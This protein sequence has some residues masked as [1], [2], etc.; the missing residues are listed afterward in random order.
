MLFLADIPIMIAWIVLSNRRPLFSIPFKKRLVTGAVILLSTLAFFLTASHSWVIDRNSFVYDRNYVIKYLGIYYFHYY[1]TSNFIKDNISRSKP[2]TV[3]EKDTV[4]KYFKQKQQE[5]KAEKKYTGIAK[6]KNLIIIQMEAIQQ[7]FIN[8]TINGKQI[9]PN[10]NKLASE[11]AYFPNFF[12]QIGG[13]NTSDAELLTNTSTY[14]AKD[15]AVYFRFPLNTFNSLP[16]L[17]KKEGYSVYSSHAYQA[18]FWNRTT[19]HRTLGFDKFFSEKD[20]TLDEKLGWG[21]G[22]SS[23]LRQSLDKVRAHTPFYGFFITLTSHYPYEAT[24]KSDFN[25]GE[26]EGKMLGKYMKAA[27]YADK[28]IG[29]LVAYMKKLGLYDNT[30]LV[31]YG[32]HFGMPR[33][34]GEDIQKYLNFSG[35]DFDWMKMNK[36]PYIIHYPGLLNGKVI[37]TTGG[38]LDTLPTVANILGID[39][40]YA[41]GKDLVNAKEGSGYAVLRNGSVA[42][43]KFYYVSSI[44]KAFDA[45]NGS[46]VDIEKYKKELQTHHHELKVSDIIMNK[47]GFKKLGDFLK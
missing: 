47:D 27:N 21:L 45:Q 2:L 18:S 34:Q 42:T 39:V 5:S 37:S 10:M 36:V 14:P 4:N 13:G 20:F 41:F 31:I 6:G 43:D 24:A 23:F 38:Q 16:K 22:D 11:S 46:P 32:D 12:S 28:S 40:P 3:E 15:G 1:D 29:D 8:S 35:T 26:Y 44:S 9:T 30:V 7:F 17:L 19:M 33:H 25:A